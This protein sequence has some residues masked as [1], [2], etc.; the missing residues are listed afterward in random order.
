MQSLKT[1]LAFLFLSAVPALDADVYRFP[2]SA[3]VVNVKDYGAKGDGVTDDTLA[4]NTAISEN[5]D[6]SRYRSNPMIYF[7]AGTYLVSGPIESRVLD[8]KIPKGKVW[9]AGWR[10]MMVLLGEDRE[11]TVIKLKDN[12][13]GYT[14]AGKKKWLIA[15]G[16]E[17]DKRDN[18]RGG[19]NRGFRHG[20]LNL[21]ID[22]GNGNPGAVAV[23]FLS[24]NRGTIDDVTL[25]AGP[26][27]GHTAIDL[28]RW[29]PGPAMVMNVDIIGF[30]TGIELE[31]YQYGM[32][33]E[34]IRMTGQ[35]NVGVHNTKNV[36]AMRN[37]SFTGSVPFYTAD[38]GSRHSFI[39]LLDSEIIGE[40]TGGMSALQSGG[41]VNLRRVEVSGFAKVLDD[42]GKEDKDLPANGHTTIEAHNQGPSLDMRGGSGRELNLP[43]EDIPVVTPPENP[44]DWTD[45]GGTRESLQNAIDSGAEYIFINPV[46]TLEVSTP[47]IVR[48]N[49]K[50]IMGLNGHIKAADGQFAL[51]IENGSAPVVMLRHLYLD[52]GFENVSDRTVALV[53]GDV[54]GLG[55]ERKGGGVRAR[56]EG[57]THIVDVIGRGY[58]IGDGH[59]FWAR[60]LNAEFGSDP[61]LTNAGDAWIMGFKMETS[62]AGSK[63][64]PDSTPS[65]LNQG[66][67][68]LEVFAGLLYTLGNNSRHA[69]K[70]PA[71]TNGPQARL[72]VSYRNNGTPSTHY[73]I[74]LR[75]G[76]LERGED[77][78]KSSIKGEGAALLSDGP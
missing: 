51:R 69:P 10:S 29:W 3:Q 9:S 57:K 14:D 19:G 43:I 33:F 30:N 35:R 23:D 63:D 76:T 28:T 61:L 56:G 74:V 36:V 73:P 48:N 66:E 8:P 77:L 71:F 4:I 15:T 62:S 12:A 18:Y 1:F 31:H 68:R 27:S 59:R 65:L 54:G 46:Q 17:G 6:K 70:V 25:K 42:T 21:T 40:G 52:G 49:V 44:E 11:R 13:P 78:M 41:I 34:N 37:V 39:S 67:G 20:I 75:Q 24:N 50:L 53:H 32:T 38:P 7:P 47:V 2:D 22:V 45:G 5:I 60:Q 55:T 26:G 64:A 16:S 58:D 72:A